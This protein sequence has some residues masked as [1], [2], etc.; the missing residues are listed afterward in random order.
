MKKYSMVLLPALGLLITE[1]AFPAALTLTG[2]EPLLAKTN[3]ASITALL[4]AKN[5]SSNLITNK[6]P[7]A[8]SGIVDRTDDNN[9]DFNFIGLQ[10]IQV[11]IDSYGSE[12]AISRS[13]FNVF[14]ASG[15]SV[16]SSLSSG[17]KPQSFT[18]V[19][20]SIPV[21]AAFWL[22][23]SVLTGLFGLSRS[24]SLPGVVHK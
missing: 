23:G 10:K 16:K 8:Q 15:K 3:G 22:F 7:S 1:S 5:D 4:L 20:N 14:L 24:K 21:P 9:A 17:K 11:T 6:I 19:I 13:S 18:A 2:N 12:S